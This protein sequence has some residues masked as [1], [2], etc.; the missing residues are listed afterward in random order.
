MI[1]FILFFPQTSVL[2]EQV[3]LVLIS[4]NQRT[5]T[6]TIIVMNRNLYFLGDFIIILLVDLQKKQPSRMTL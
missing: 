4:C 3:D 5:L 2:H 6:M 1:Y